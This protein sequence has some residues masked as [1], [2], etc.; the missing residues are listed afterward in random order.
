[1]VLNLPNT[2]TLPCC[3]DPNHKAILIAIVMNHNINIFGGSLLPKT[4]R[5]G[6]ADENGE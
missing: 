4:H 5:L 6:N 3:S 2:A 1:M